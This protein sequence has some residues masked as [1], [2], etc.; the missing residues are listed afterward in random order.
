[1][2]AVLREGVPLPRLVVAVLDLAVEV[3]GEQVF[4]RHRALVEGAPEAGPRPAVV[5]EPLAADG[6][7]DPVREGVVGDGRETLPERGL[8]ARR[9]RVLV[10]PV[11]VEQESECRGR[12]DGRDEIGHAAL[13]AGL[14]RLLGAPDAVSGQRE[15]V[16]H[17]VG[18]VAD[19]GPP[20]VVALDLVPPFDRAPGDRE[21]VAD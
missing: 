4:A 12:L 14:V 20:L 13:V 16:A 5:L 3:L 18:D 2:W 8:I 15:L 1:P 6:G 11:V 17:G 19:A 10:A 7:G 9:R 21:L